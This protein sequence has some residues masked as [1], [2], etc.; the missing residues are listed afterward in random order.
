MSEWTT[1]ERPS[2]RCRACGCWQSSQI[3]ALAGDGPPQTDIA[4]VGEAPGEWEEAQDANFV[5]RAGEMLNGCLTE[6]G[7]LRAEVFVCNSV[8]CRPVTPLRRNRKP[9]MHEIDCCR[10]YTLDE[11]AGV[12][13]RVIVA[14]GDV[15][16]T[17]L[18]GKQLG[19]VTEHRGKVRWSDEWNAWIIPT[20]HPA[21]ALR[22]YAERHW[23]VADLRLARETVER[24]GPA[25]VETTHVD[26]IRTLDDLYAMRDDVLSY[27]EFA[28]DWETNGVHLTKSRGF[29]M[30]I[31]VREGHAYVIPR[32]LSGMMP[33]WAHRDFPIVDNVL[34]ELLLS[35]LRK[36]GWHLAF[37]NNVSRT[38]LG[39]WPNNPWFCGM[40]AHHA[41]ANHLGGRAHGLKLCASMYTPMGRYDDPLD[42]WLVEHGYTDQGKPD[43]GKV[44]LAPDEITHLYNGSD[45]DATLRLKNVLVPRLHAA[46]LWKV[47]TTDLMPVS[48]EHQEIDRIGVRIN[49]SYLDELSGLLGSALDTMRVELAS[50]AENDTL[51]PSSHKQMGELFYDTLGLPILARTNTG[52]PSTREDVLVQLK[53][54]HP[55]VP[56]LLAYRAHEKIKST[57]VDGK[58]TAAGRKKALRAVIDDDG[59]ARMN[60]LLAAAETF[61]FIT[62]RPFAIHTWPKT[63]PKSGIPSVRALIIPDDHYVFLT[64]DYTQQEFVIQSIAAGQWDMVEALLDRGE[65][66]HEKVTRELGGHEKSSYLWAPDFGSAYVEI[67][68][69]HWKSKDAYD[70]YKKQRQKFKNVNFMILFR[71]GARKLARMALGC[72]ADYRTRTPCKLEGVVDC[73]HEQTAARY[74]SDYYDLYDAIKW[75]QYQTIKTLTRTGKVV[76]LFDTYRTLPGIWDSN[77]YVRLEAERQGCNFPIQNGGA[78][79]MRRA[80][81]RTQER[82][83]GKPPLRAPFPGRVVFTLHDE[84]TAQVREDLVEDGDYIV[85]TC[86]EAP[87]RELGGRSFR[88]SGVRTTCWGG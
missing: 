29:C 81:L 10:G 9:T 36:I 86:M 48:T 32:Y 16:M 41:L 39:I 49:C 23:I 75:W 70:E 67:D 60:T 78:H 80:L 34:R 56:L 22:K 17:S 84:M 77:A 6:A 43:Y 66:V 76:G 21:Y 25:P 33:A 14:L 88:T 68:G 38:T 79:V 65:D 74:I 69:D 5:G 57:Y 31:S 13:P 87:Y 4:L 19:G 37:D 30:S 51:N 58:D 71:G 15:A 45:S 27:E 42:Q 63:D 61:R 40:I 8:R 24:G 83:R 35:A 1:F 44:W 3:N 53:E 62:R 26:V 82:F 2:L 54:M 47:F 12:K 85:K 46:G 50:Y 55:A 59:Y 28:Y 7:L 52:Q 64:R 73:S 72:T 18:I 20:F 11:L